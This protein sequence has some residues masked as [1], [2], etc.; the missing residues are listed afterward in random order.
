[1][2]IIKQKLTAFVLA[3][4]LSLTC[5]AIMPAYHVKA[6]AASSAWI[7][8]WSTSPVEFNLKKMLDLDWIK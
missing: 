5:I 3:L 2:K 6:A 4:C 1:M 7:G 8:A